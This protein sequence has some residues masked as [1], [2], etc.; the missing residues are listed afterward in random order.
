MPLEAQVEIEQLGN[1]WWAKVSA[2]DRP[3]DMA[4]RSQEF[5]VNNYSSL[6]DELVNFLDGI[7][8]RPAVPAPAL[9]KGRKANGSI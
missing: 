6:F 1:V 3:R 2:R 9:K 5:R 4:F 7:A 8:P